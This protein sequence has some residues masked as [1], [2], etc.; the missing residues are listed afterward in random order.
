[1]A[2]DIARKCSQK[3]LDHA[4]NSA[5]DTPKLASKGQA[6]GKK[7]A[8][9]TGDLIGNKMADKLTVMSKNFFETVTNG[10]DK[11]IPKK[12]Y[13]SRKQMQEITND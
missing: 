9:A 8:E 5:M 4:N 11:E 2:K 6:E 10:H 12:G 7:R 13:I 3:P 1:M